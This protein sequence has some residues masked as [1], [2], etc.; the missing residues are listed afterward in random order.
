MASLQQPLGGT[1]A[2]AATLRREVL[3]FKIVELQ[4]VAERLRLRKTGESGGEVW[5]PVKR[6]V[7]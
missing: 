6:R 3:S 2:A 5:M 4:E 1:A 7:A